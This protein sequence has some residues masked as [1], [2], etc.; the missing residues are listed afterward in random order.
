MDAMTF[1]ITLALLEKQSLSFSC[2]II[3]KK[4]RKTISQG[5]VEQK[6]GMGIEY[7]KLGFKLWPSVQFCFRGSANTG[8]VSAC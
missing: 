5:R 2:T 6:G 1:T 3:K 7:F 4:K 8:I